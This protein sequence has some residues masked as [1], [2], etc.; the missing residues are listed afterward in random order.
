MSLVGPGGLGKTSHFCDA[1][2]SHNFLPN[3]WQNITFTKNISLV[4]KAWQK[5][6]I[7]SSFLA[8]ILKWLKS[9]KTAYLCLMTRVKNLSKQRV[10]QKSS[11]RSSQ[12][13]WLLICQNNLSH[14]IK[15]SCTIDLNTTHIVLFKSPRDVHQIDHLNYQILLSNIVRPYPTIFFLPSSLAK[16]TINKRAQS[17]CLIWSTGKKTSKKEI[18]IA[19]YLNALKKIKFQGECALNTINGYIPFKTDNSL[20]FKY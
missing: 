13:N 10:R 8:W 20:S 5:S 11:C 1:C 9:W 12:E 18:L 2:F 14:Q 3:H 6:W 19:F 17:C 16:E 15:W 4:L 7:L